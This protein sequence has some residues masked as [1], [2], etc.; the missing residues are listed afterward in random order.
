MINN[1]RFPNLQ[2]FKRH[3]DT[4]SPFTP[5]RARIEYVR[6]MEINDEITNQII[7]IYM[8]NKFMIQNEKKNVNIMLKR[9]QNN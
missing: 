1:K 5:K 4:D 9:L 7:E 8:I 2:L 6:I 3:I